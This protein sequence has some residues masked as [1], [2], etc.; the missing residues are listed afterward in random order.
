MMT[1]RVTVDPSRRDGRWRRWWRVRVSGGGNGGDL[2]R[3]IG[4]P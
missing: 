1:T 3:G 4:G 2:G